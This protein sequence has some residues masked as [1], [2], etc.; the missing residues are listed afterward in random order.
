MELMTEP[1][2]R[3]F[4]RVN[5]HTRAQLSQG[6]S[7]CEVKLQ[8]ISLKGLLVDK[9]D[10]MTPDPQTPISVTIALGEDEAIA[11]Q[12]HL[13]RSDNNQWGLTFSDIDVGSM[14]HLRRLIELNL[15]DPEAAERELTEMILAHTDGEQ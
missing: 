2:R 7:V 8:D 3:R 5:F 13:A 9:T 4:S 10:Q 14:G 15:G 6:D 1:E 11:L 12:A